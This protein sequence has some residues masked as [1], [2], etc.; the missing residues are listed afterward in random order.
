MPKRQTIIS[1]SSFLDLFDTTSPRLDGR[2]TPDFQKRQQYKAES[3]STLTLAR[4]T[5]QLKRTPLKVKEEKT[6]T[7]LTHK[8]APKPELELS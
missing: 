7:L 4:D 8:Q 1:R 5:F 6:Y 2:Q 3:P